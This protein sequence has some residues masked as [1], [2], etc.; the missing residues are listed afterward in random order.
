MDLTRA[1]ELHENSTFAEAPLSAEKKKVQEAMD[2]VASE[3]D[4]WIG[5]NWYYHDDL[6]KFFQFNIPKGCSVL[7]IGCGTGDLMSSV[8][9]ARAVGIDISREFVRAAQAKYPHWEFSQ[10]DAE[11]LTLT[12]KF[13]YIII[14]DTLGYLE[15]IQKAFREL[16]KVS[17]SSTRIIITFHS[18]LWS[19]ILRI[20][21]LLKL[22]M[23]QKRLNWLNK[24]DVAGLLK[25]E[26]FEIIKQGRRF[27]C[28]KYI[29][30]ISYL[31]NRYVANLPLLNTFC[32]TGYFIARPASHGGETQ[33]C[34]VSIVVPARNEKGNI[35]PLVQR[36]PKLGSR[37]EVIFVEGHSTDGTLEEIKR[38]CAKYAHRDLEL[39]Y[40]IQDGE[41]KADAV[42]KGFSVARGDIFMILDADLSVS[43][44]ELPKFYN[45]LVAGKGE[46]VNGSRLV[47]PRERESMM[48]LNIIGNK[49]FSLMFTWL[50][51]Q[52]VKDTL[53][54]TKAISRD[55]YL[56][57]SVNRSYFGDFDPFGDF[58]LIFGA[59]KLNLKI[60]EVP[61]RYKARQ[62]GK[63]NISRFRHGWLLLRMTLFA[64]N[65]LKF[66]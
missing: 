47:Y 18:F 8:R 22:K 29:P 55:N 52:R 64:M 30:L 23:P 50:L 48:T 45:V 5:R 40:L 4:K 27:V 20:A 43:P 28:P 17:N 66:L 46:L 9:P 15:D 62:Y 37:T 6:R 60:V 13:D 59:A 57:L 11:N 16:H 42:R 44:E 65:R 36:V 1:T 10:M 19:P 61:V 24:G 58:D 51:G 14:S 31:L 3:R 63:T 32:I 41:G 39:N 25:L 34:S 26:G 12:E 49:F 38:V 33:E 53:C 54:G 7:E 56:V 35:E 2:S 21:E